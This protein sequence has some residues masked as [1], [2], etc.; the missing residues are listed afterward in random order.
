M[1]TPSTLNELRRFM[2]SLNWEDMMGQIKQES[3]SRLAILGPVNAG[4]STLFN[5]LRGRNVSST[6]AVPGTTR[7]LVADWFGPFI[8]VDTPGFGEVGGVDRAEIALQGIAHAAVVVLLLDAAAGLRQ[9]DQDLYRR[10][11]ATGRPVVVAMN[12]I[13]LVGQDRALVLADAS[14]H[15]D[16]AQ[17]IPISAKRGEGIASHLMPAVFQA[18]P[19]MAVAVGRALPAYRQMAAHQ[20]IRNA[21]FLNAA[22]GAE[23]IPALDL[24]LL[25]TSQVRL[26]LR[27]AAIY[28]ET[29]SP[30]RAR[31]LIATMAGSILL[32]YLGGEAAKLLPGPG[33]LLAAAFTSASTF[34]IGEVATRYFEGGKQLSGQQ[35][36]DLYQQFRQKWSIRS[37]LR[38][39]AITDPQ[40]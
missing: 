21:A 40:S 24:P 36:Q 25:L 14:A 6:S 8:L 7:Q 15:L 5:A 18:D 31:E 26:V 23:P 27:I 33:W 19:T 38:K 2:S 28:G 37:R 17:V 11:V 22:I 34:A 1:R 39:R 16:G 13:D 12:K 4:K 10:L 35:M 30:E 29:I 9:S 32:R 20:V 3:Q